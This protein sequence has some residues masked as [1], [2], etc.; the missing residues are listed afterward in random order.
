MSS[1]R[2]DP[3]FVPYEQATAPTG[4][5]IA[6]IT[7]ASQQVLPNVARRAKLTFINPNVASNINMWIAPAPIAAAANGAG[8]IPIFPG[9]SFTVDDQCNCA[10]NAAAGSST[11]NLTILESL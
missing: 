4:Y 2:F 7:T 5:G 6:G 8:S 1:R 9:E 11:G 3:A 10:W